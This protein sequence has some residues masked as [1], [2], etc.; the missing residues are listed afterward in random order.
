MPE[1]LIKKH[2][3]RRESLNK[4]L[5][6]WLSRLRTKKAFIRR[7]SANKKFIRSGNARLISEIFWLNQLLTKHWYEVSLWRIKKRSNRYSNRRRRSKRTNWDSNRRRRS[8][9]RYKRSRLF[10][11]WRNEGREGIWTKTDWRAEDLGKL[12]D[13]R[14]LYVYQWN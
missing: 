6:Y 14:D 3:L 2:L 13:M 10:L 8:K 11:K 7:R 5:D 12:M 1:L 9:I 4:Q